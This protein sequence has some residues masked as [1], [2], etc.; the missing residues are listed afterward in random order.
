MFTYARTGITDASEFCLTFKAPFLPPSA[1]RASVCCKSSESKP[2]WE[3]NP[4][5]LDQANGAY[6]NGWQPGVLF[7]PKLQVTYYSL[8]PSS[9]HNLSVWLSDVIKR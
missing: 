6:I 1:K 2:G 3:A 9:N 7:P 5:C 4:T 8:K